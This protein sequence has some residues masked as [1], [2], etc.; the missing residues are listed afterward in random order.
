MDSYERVGGEEFIHVPSSP[1]S[2]CVIG[3]RRRFRSLHSQNSHIFQAFSKGLGAQNQRVF[4]HF[5]V[6]LFTLLKNKSTVETHT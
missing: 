4:A 2:L 5:S 3:Y 1:N 6:E